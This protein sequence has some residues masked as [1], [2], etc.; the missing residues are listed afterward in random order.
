MKILNVARTALM[1][2]A[3]TI[4][5]TLIIQISPKNA[6]ADLSSIYAIGRGVFVLGDFLLE[7]TKGT[8]ENSELKAIQDSFIQQETKMGNKISFGPLYERVGINSKAIVLTFNATVNDKPAP[9]SFLFILDDDFATVNGCVIW[10]DLAEYKA[11]SSKKAL[12]SHYAKYF[13]VDLGPVDEEDSKKTSEVA[14]ETKPLAETAAV[15]VQPQP[16]TSSSETTAAVQS[17]TPPTAPAKNPSEVLKELKKMK[18]DGLI[19]E[20]EFNAKK[21]QILDKM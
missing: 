6:S 18:D 14:A 11:N 7:K 1:L 15:P 17:Q 10:D 3:V 12:A 9:I 19:T 20:E 2:V 16:A 21:K 4:I 8:K 13:G 5:A